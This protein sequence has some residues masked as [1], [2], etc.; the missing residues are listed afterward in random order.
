MSVYFATDQYQIKCSGNV[1]LGVDLDAS[2]LYHAGLRVSWFS[3]TRSNLGVRMVSVRQDVGTG[4]QRIYTLEIPALSSSQTASDTSDDEPLDSYIIIHDLEI[5]QNEDGHAWKLVFSEIQWFVN[6]V[7]EDTI[8]GITLYSDVAGSWGVPLIGI[9]PTIE[10]IQDASPSPPFP[11][12]VSHD[13]GHDRSVYQTLNA[14]FRYLDEDGVS[15]V[16][17]PISH[18]ILNAP[19]GDDDCGDGD[20]CYDEFYDRVTTPTDSW[21]IAAAFD[22]INIEEREGPV[23][24]SCPCPEN[25]PGPNVT[26]DVYQDTE[27][28]QAWSVSATLYT[29]GFDPATYKI[30]TKNACGCPP[31]EPVEVSTGETRVRNDGEML[32]DIDSSISWATDTKAIQTGGG[33]CGPCGPPDG[34]GG[35]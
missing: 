5:R 22:L 14:G 25:C 12:A 7:L 34:G 1:T 29:K 10:L 18:R 8:P 6:G 3:G 13:G 4:H 19:E 32:W 2:G 33:P 17:T 31:D 11:A 23:H 24:Y 27:R 9:L 28:S 26:Y 16:T 20:R 21:N 35:D 15:W 30:G